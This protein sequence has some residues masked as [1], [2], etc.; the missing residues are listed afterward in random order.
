VNEKLIAK[1]RIKLHSTRSNQSG[2]SL[3]ELVIVI[4]IFALL[5]VAIVGVFISTNRASEGASSGSN[6]SIRAVTVAN[7]LQTGLS[8]SSSFTITLVGTFTEAITAPGI[9]ASGATI[10]RYWVFGFDGSAYYRES[11]TAIPLPNS[12][13]PDLTGWSTLT[14]ELSK[15]KM[16]YFTRFGTNTLQW[17][18][19]ITAEN[20]ETMILEGASRAL[21]VLGTP[22]SC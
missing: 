9:D 4:G 10:C 20:G 15:A 2:L 19:Q 21:S 13:D 17:A 14:N 11:P 7:S 3:V 18:F 8:Y 5:S 1:L 22:P 16:N 6:L 12:A